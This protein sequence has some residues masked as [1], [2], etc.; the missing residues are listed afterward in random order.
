[1]RERNRLD[2]IADDELKHM[3]ETPRWSRGWV[4]Y[5]IAERSYQEG[6]SDALMAEWVGQIKA[7]ARVGLHVSGKD[8]QPAPAV[9]EKR[10]EW[11]YGSRYTEA[12]KGERRTHT[13]TIFTA[14]PAS[15]PAWFCL[16]KITD[17]GCSSQT[18]LDRRS[19]KE[20]RGGG[21]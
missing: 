18:G 4:G 16:N 10:R 13:E 6:V 5:R 2:E 1:M 17:H 20:R 12:R 21:R 9:G 3:D 7:G 14:Y 15:S 11:G 8:V 19:G